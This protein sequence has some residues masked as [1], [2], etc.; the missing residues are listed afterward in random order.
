MEL[1]SSQVGTKPL[2]NIKA[3]DGF[4]YRS[5]SEADNSC[6]PLCMAQPILDVGQQALAQPLARKDMYRCTVPHCRAPVVAGGQLLRHMAAHQLAG[7][8]GGWL[9]VPQHDPCGFC[10]MPLVG[11]AVCSSAGPEKLIRAHQG[12]ELLP[13]LPQLQLCISCQDLSLQRMHQRAS[14]L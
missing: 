10:G 14:A 3:F 9:H 6:Y 11:R 13:Q 5:S 2:P 12:G 8:Y 7:E 4:P 1:L